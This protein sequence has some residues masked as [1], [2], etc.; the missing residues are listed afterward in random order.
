MIP[1]PPASWTDAALAGGIVV[2]YIIAIVLIVAA[3]IIIVD[4]VE[5]RLGMHDDTTDRDKLGEAVGVFDDKKRLWAPYFEN[6]HPL[7]G[8]RDR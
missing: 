3:V 5:G 2:A 1:N 8:K 6:V 7:H 4:V